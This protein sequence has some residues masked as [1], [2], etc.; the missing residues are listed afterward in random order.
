LVCCVGLPSLPF[1]K[2]TL[3]CALESHPEGCFVAYIEIML[4]CGSFRSYVKI[5]Y[6][7][8]LILVWREGVRF[9]SVYMNQYHV[10]IFFKEQLVITA[11]IPRFFN[12]FHWPM[13][14]FIHQWLASH[15]VT[16]ILNI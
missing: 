14:L 16:I 11:V 7:L 4:F 10:E 9:N 5:F 2:K 3:L 15:M 12:P 13:Y 1:L 8:V 6:S